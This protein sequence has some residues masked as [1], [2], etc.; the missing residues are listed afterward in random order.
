M[1][2]CGAED[3]RYAKEECGARRARRYGYRGEVRSSGESG[4]R[5]AK[6]PRVAARAAQSRVYATAANARRSGGA[7]QRQA[8]AADVARVRSHLIQHAERRPPF[9]FLPGASARRRLPV[10]S[11]LQR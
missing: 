1:L 7:R 8:A 10:F 3:R 4:A 11:L 6:A 9:L 5:V 2:P